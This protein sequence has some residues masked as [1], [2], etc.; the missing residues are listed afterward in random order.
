[1]SNLES[2]LAQA[3]HIGADTRVEIEAAK[4]L[5]DKAKQRAADAK[6]DADDRAYEGSGFASPRYLGLVKVAGVWGANFNAE[7]QDSRDAQS[8]M[9]ASFMAS[10]TGQTDKS[11]NGGKRAGYARVI[12]LGTNA[13]R[14]RFALQA[15][16]DHWRSEHDSAPEGESAKDAAERKA[17][18]RRYLTPC[19]DAP[20]V[21]GGHVITNS[22]GETKPPKF[23]GRPA[24][25]VNG[26]EIK[27]GRGTDRDA[28]FAAFAALYAEHGDKVLA[29]DVIDAFLDNGGRY[30]AD[31]NPTVE[32]VSGA[33]LASLDELM[34]LGGKSS[35]DAAM[36]MAAHA[37]IDRIRAQGFKDSQVAP[38]VEAPVVEAP[39]V[40]E[41][42]AEAT[43]DVGDVLDGV[44]VVFGASDVVPSQDGTTGEPAKPARP[45]RN[46]GAKT[47]GEVQAG[48]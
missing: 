45:R 36:L 3:A 15:R 5:A 9:A 44:G 7:S 4:T 41:P 31:S 29:R 19:G 47:A 43:S 23:C 6:S 2:L 39:V 34:A 28:Q 12:G 38:V 42:E 30:K 21:E 1:M 24:K 22:K 20:D 18:A 33:I 37:V 11:L 27:Y 25:I 14:V 46:R 13:E 48:A 8:A 40:S 17:T 26:V 32:S 35:G 10:M 16:L